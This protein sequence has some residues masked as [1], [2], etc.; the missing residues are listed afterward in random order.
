MCTQ[1]DD[2]EALREEEEEALRLQRKEAEGLLPED[3]EQPTEAESEAEADDDAEEAG[4]LGAAF[5]RVCRI[6]PLFMLAAHTVLLWL[7]VVCC[8]RGLRRPKDVMMML[9]LALHQMPSCSLRKSL[10]LL[11]P[12]PSLQGV[13]CAI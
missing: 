9:I 8:W 2:E 13:A 6:T 7:N 3:F 10:T 1:S 5:A 12:A 11:D 4:T